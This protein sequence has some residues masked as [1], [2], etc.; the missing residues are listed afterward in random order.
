MIDLITRSSWLMYVLIFVGKL[1]EVTM[2]SLRSQLIHKGHRLP[3]ALIAAVEYAFWLI[4][5]ATALSGFAEDPL[6]VVILV[7]AFSAGQVCGSVLEEKLAFG[8]NTITAIFTDES[9]ALQAA[10]QIRNMNQALTIMHAEGID[11]KKRYAIMLAVRRRHV[12]RIKDLLYSCD[13]GVM[14]TV[15]LTQ[16]V[17]NA[18]IPTS[19][20][21]A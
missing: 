8:Y 2:S 6:K 16:Q 11:Q 21:P 17:S 19:S 9:S 1:L 14:V 5:T 3:G 12:Q 4:L 18:F 7:A 15:S 10:Q 13:S 20:K